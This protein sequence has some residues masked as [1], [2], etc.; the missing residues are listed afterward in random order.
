[1]FDEA[2]AAIAK[3]KELF[4]KHSISYKPTRNF[5]EYFVQIKNNLN[6][7]ALLFK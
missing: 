6:A 4:K 3:Q 1:M 7:L 2:N 5:D